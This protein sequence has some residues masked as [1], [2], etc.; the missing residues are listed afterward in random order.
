MVLRR[1]ILRKGDG[2]DFPDLQDEV[3]ELQKKLGFSQNE[4][5]GKFGS[6]TE[7]AVKRFQSANSL[8]DDGIV[9]QNTWIALL[10]EYVQVF[11]PHPVR[12]AEFDID[13]IV[14]SIAFP[15]IRASARNSIPIILRECKASGISDRGKIAYI[16]A[17]AQH[18]SH[19]GRLMVELSTGKQYEGR[20][21]LGNTQPGDGP[22]YKGR[23]FVQITGR[24]NYTFWKDRLGVNLVNFPEKAAE[25]TTATKILVQGMRDGTFTGF[26][27]GHFI[28]GATQNF[29]A[30]RQIINDHDKAQEIAAIARNFLRVL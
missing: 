13:K 12:M 11:L 14:S 7:E 18:E 2:I 5:D 28:A 20:I 21:D 26:R 25:P 24:R 1:P 23:G 15:L 9:G 29:V 3:T 19:L 10:D 4:I 16:L 17:T 22:R 6:G 27:L 8:L 30:A